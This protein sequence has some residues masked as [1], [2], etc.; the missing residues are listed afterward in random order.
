VADHR[1]KSAVISPTT[2]RAHAVCACTWCTPE[3]STAGLAES[4]LDSHIQSELARLEWANSVLLR[5]NSRANRVRVSGERVRLAGIADAVQARA[6]RNLGAEPHP[7]GLVTLMAVSRDQHLRIEVV[8]NL[9]KTGNFYVIGE[10]APSLEALAMTLVERPR[11]LLVDDDARR[12]GGPAD[13][14]LIRD[15]SPDTRICMCAVSG[16]E[17]CDYTDVVVGRDLPS[18]DLARAL[19][20]LAV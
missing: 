14:A 17:Q 18:A 4:L 7:I 11:L 16:D 3:F 5:L 9:Q 2:G 19:L 13:V 6:E 12:V 20:A 15:L 8:D 10:A 1:L